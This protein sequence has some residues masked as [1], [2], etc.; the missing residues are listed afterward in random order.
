[1]GQT[2]RIG[3]EFRVN[4]YT[5]S[6]QE[7]PRIARNSSG[8]FIV[9]W[10]SWTQDGS[11]FGVFGQHFDA[12]GVALGGEFQVNTYSTNNQYE[13]AVTVDTAGNFT[14][15]WQSRLQDGSLNGVYAQRY[16]GAGVPSGGP[17]RVN[18]YTTNEQQNPAVDTDGPG[19]F[20]VAWD[21]SCGSTFPCTAQ[22]GSYAGVFSQRYSSTGAV[23]GT[24]FR[25]NTATSDEQSYPSV[26]KADAGN[27]VV[28][29][30]SYG[31]EPSHPQDPLP[32]YGIFGKRFS[33]TGA[34]VGSEFQVN[35]FTFRSQDAPSVSMNGSGSF[36]VAWE[37]YGQL[38]TVGYDVVGQRYN[39]SGT[40]VGSEFIVNTYTG[41]DQKSPVVAMADTGSFVI[42]WRSRLQDGWA[43]GIY[44]QRYNSDGTRHGPEFRVNTYTIGEQRTPSIAMD[45]SG[46]FV[47]AWSS[48]GQDGSATGVY[49]QRFSAADCV[50]PSATGPSNQTVCQGSTAFFTATGAGL[51]PF[52]Y[53][54]RKN[55]VNLT[56]GGHIVGSDAQTLK[57]KLVAAADVGSYSCVVS[58]GCLPPAN[59]TSASGTLTVGAGQSAGAVANLRLQK[60]NSG[61]NLKLTWNNTTNATDYV[62]YEENVADGTFTTST[63]T[64]TSGVTGITIPMPSVNKFYLVAGRNATCGVGPQN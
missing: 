43:S 12:S 46:N 37:S 32:D 50:L 21:S 49:A 56:D 9:V 53:Q 51:G 40:K 25:A 13:P 22:D 36:V 39:S 55:G 52:T 18:T 19:S 11:G 15:V 20:V 61:A 2:A 28:V 26:S 3:P 7:A 30:Q 47:V 54:W 29:W 23:A 44:G 64:S 1:M 57:V 58:D 5:T 6:Y 27:F 8:E 63:A 4:T 31:Q 41:D 10:Q 16:N 45:G 62:L 60:I 34:A 48:A 33:S 17:F 42:V 38:G 24:E 14:V 35:T 59:A